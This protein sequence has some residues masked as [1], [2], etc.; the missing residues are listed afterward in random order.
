MHNDER[1][2]KIW[3]DGSAFKNPGGESGYAGV[4]EWPES[5]DRPLEVV[6][7]GTLE[8][9]TN[10]RMEL[11]ACVKALELVRKH[12]SAWKA[13]GI[14]RIQIV[15]D[16][17]YVC[18]NRNR[19]ATWR[20]AG[21]R[22]ASGAFIENIDL[23][24]DYLRLQAVG[25]EIVWQRGKISEVN[26]LV[27]KLAK[28]AAKSPLKKKDSGYRPGATS[29]AGSDRSAAQAFPAKGQTE[30]IKVLK[31]ELEGVGSQR[32]QKISF[33]LYDQKAKQ[34]KGKYYAYLRKEIMHRH[35]WYTVR[36][37]GTHRYPIM[38]EFSETESQ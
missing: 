12:R 6:F 37:G 5:L 36:F 24:K 21:W 33:F 4:I 15:T 34:L 31:R 35:H 38:E 19:P 17:E 25:A 22:G 7:T 1:A 29:R 8:Q 20:K 14:H 18:N 27:D 2:L 9:S 16:S 30:T 3:V 23:W 28:E 32:E 26:K 10:N 11:M 13:L